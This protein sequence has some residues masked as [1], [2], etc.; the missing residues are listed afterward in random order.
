M[1]PRLLDLTKF[2]KSLFLFGPRQVG[3]TYLIKNTVSADI[4]INLLKHD[5]FLRYLK[6]PALISQEITALKKDNPVIVIDEIQRCPELLNEVHLVMENIPNTQFILTGSSARKLRRAGVNL[7]GGRAITLHLYPFTYQELKEDFIL[8]DALRFGEIPSV[9]LEKNK[10]DKI[11]L[12][13]SYIETYLKEEIQQESLTRNIPAFAKFLE[14]A[15]YENG[16]IL[17]FQ[18]LSREVGVHSK[19]IKEYFHILEDTLI[20]FFLYPYTKSH[21]AKIISHPKFYFFDCGV[22]SAL[23]GELNSELKSQTL[24]YGRAFEHFILLE[25]IKLCSYSERD[26]KLSFFRTK[27]GAEVDLILE[28]EN[29]ITWAIEIKSSNEPVLSEVRGLR[30]FISDHNYAKAFCI[31]L[32]PRKFTKEGIEFIP[33]G[34]FMQLLWNDKKS[35]SQT[36]TN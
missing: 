24:P 30:S 2:R 23:K 12:L 11:R 5:E 33:W 19:T 28:L 8:D 14:L 18:N 1:I 21:R 16:N 22:V 7:L 10:A 27:D 17:N 26:I 25:I 36:A 20:G 32:T 9:A 34:E 3:K 4:F 6:N 35:I 31:C 29:S 13:K 15:G